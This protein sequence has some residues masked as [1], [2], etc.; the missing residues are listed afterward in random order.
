MKRLFTFLLLLAVMPAAAQ[1]Q[2]GQDMYVKIWD[3]KD[4]PH[5][6]EIT[7]K[8]VNHNGF[9]YNTTSTELYIFK[10][11]PAK[12]TG[13]AFVVIPGGGY[14]CVC[15][16]FEGDKVAKWLAQQGITA[17]VLKYRL[18]NGHSEVPLEDTVEALRT[19]RKMAGELNIDPKKVGVMGSS[20]GG[21]LAAYA[22]TLAPEEDKPNFTCLFYPVITSQEDVTHRDTFYNL[23]GRQSSDYDRAFFSLE[24]RVTKTTPPAIIFHSDA[25]QVVPPV[26]SSRY[27]NALKK[28]GIPAELHIYPNGWHGWVM[29]PEYEQYERWQASLL[30]WLKLQ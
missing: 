12:A 3:D 16:T 25:D 9:F 13:Q 30:E 21:H 29:H 23:V 24:T 8:E 26:S 6:N 7:A 19:M 18:P 20:A 2:L 28:H 14:G 10:A 15:A 1:Y 4:A 5:S 17:A 27:Y 22:S 11:D